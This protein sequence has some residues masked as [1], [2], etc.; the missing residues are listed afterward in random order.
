MQAYR[1]L[2]HNELA[3]FS[4]A[5]EMAED[6]VNDHFHLSSGFWRQHPFEVRTLAELTPAEVSS[7]ALAQVLRLRQPQ[8]E[9]RLRARDFFRICFQDH[10]FLE[11]IQREDARQRFIPLMTYVLVHEL[12]HVVRFYKFMQLFDADDRQRSLEEGRVHEISANMLR[13]VRLPHLGWVLDCYQKY[14]AAHSA[15]RYC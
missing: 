6:R 14:T 3:L 15:E 4:Q 8:D 11:L 12:V 1:G 13:K 7:E 5:L 2:D 10:N 9:R